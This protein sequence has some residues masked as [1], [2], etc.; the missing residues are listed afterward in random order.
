MFDSQQ[1]LW[2]N[3]LYAPKIAY[4]LYFREKANFAGFL[5]GS[6]LYSTS[7]TPRPTRLPVRA[8]SVCSGYSRDRYQAILPMYNRAVQPYL[9]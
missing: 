2:S 8:H 1:N 9:S 5:I 3:N 7:K 6:I 4:A